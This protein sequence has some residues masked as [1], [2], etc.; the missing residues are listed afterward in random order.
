MIASI[1]P[2]SFL[3]ASI[4]SHARRQSDP[5]LKKGSKKLVICGIDRYTYKFQILIVLD[6]L[7]SKFYLGAC[8]FFFG[9]NFRATFLGQ[10]ILEFESYSD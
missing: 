4:L 7:I 3:L 9:R 10:S 5:N 1:E 8:Y 2:G 6:F